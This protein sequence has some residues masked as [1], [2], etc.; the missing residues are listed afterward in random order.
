MKLSQDK[1]DTIVAA[2]FQA[3]KEGTT[4]VGE[5]IYMYL[6][7]NTHQNPYTS[8]TL[9][10]LVGRLLHTLNIYYLYLKVNMINIIENKEL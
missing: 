9:G 4:P 1:I 8:M 2:S 6:C 3:D 5:G 7:F 10:Y